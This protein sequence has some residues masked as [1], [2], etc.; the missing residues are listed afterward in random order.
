MKT[1]NGRTVDEMDDQGTFGKVLEKRISRKSL[2]AGAA[3]AVPLMVLGKSIA[4]AAVVGAPGSAPAKQ[5]VGGGLG[6]S[7]TT[8]TPGTGLSFTPI[9]LNTL[10][11]LTV[12]EGYEAKVLISWGDPIFQGAPKYGGLFSPWTADHQRRQFGYNADFIGFLPLPVTQRR[13]DWGLLCVNHEYTNPEM[14]FLRYDAA[15]PTKE[16]VDIELAS[17]GMSVV[18]I[19][20]I[21]ARGWTYSQ[22]S[23]YNRRIDGETPMVLTGPAAGNSLLKTSADPTGTR[24]NGMLNNCAGGVTPWGTVLTAEENFNQYF[25]NLNGLPESDSR[26]RQHQRYGLPAAASERKWERFYNRFDIA[27]E[28][29]EPFR[30]GWIVEIDPY[31]PNFVPKKRTALG[32]TKHEGGE[33]AI[34]KDGRVVV[35]VGD[36]ERFDY[37]YKFVTAGKFN[38]DN[39]AANFNLLD[40][41]TLY[42]AKYNPDGSG[43]WIPMVFGQG[44]LTAANGFASQGDVCILTRQAADLLGATKMD[45]PEDIQ[46]NP[47]NG[48]VYAVFTNNTNRGAANQPA[49]D[50]A[51]P[52]ASNA[53]GHIIEM[54]EAGNDPAATTFRWEILM[55][56]GDPNVAAQGAKYGDGEPSTISPVSAPDN[57]CF[58]NAGNLWIATD[59]QINTFRMNDGVYAVALEGPERAVPKMFFS[60]VPGG[61][62]CGPAFTPDNQTFLCAI[63]HPG[64]GGHPNAPLSSWPEGSQPTRPAV[65]IVTK[66]NGGVIGS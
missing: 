59:G 29:N 52:R 11:R 12:A 8:V 40:A 64:E 57:I 16:Q 54:T 30:F 21:Q 10:D 38:P 42:V 35:Y 50:P 43:Q 34:A 32:R 19:K 28:P 63:Q 39:R 22:S 1:E 47:V 20:K 31:D 13:S 48:K 14:M 37:V 55:L 23:G 4:S 58:D 9:T 7:A 3:A 44:P 26:K 45:R 33:T 49:P 46:L 36:D 27:K 25:G 51:N 56:C 18:E 53:H 60:G 2:I 24:V 41:G 17:H 61:E 62:I 66:K 65:V 15:N 6:S 5:V